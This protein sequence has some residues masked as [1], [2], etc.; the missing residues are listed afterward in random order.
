MNILDKPA[1]FDGCNIFLPLYHRGHLSLFPGA[2]VWLCLIPGNNTSNQ[3]TEL[4][5]SPIQHDAWSDLWRI[6]LTLKE[7]VGLVHDVFRILSAN[8][9][10]IVTAESATKDGMKLHSIEI[11][12]NAREYTNQ[13]DQTSEER[14]RGQGDELEGLRLELLA[15]LIDDIALLPNGDPRLR[16]RRVRG[17]L[18]ARRSY[19]E[20]VA[21]YVNAEAARPI[22]KTSKVIKL[23]KDNKRKVVINLPK[24]LQENLRLALGPAGANGTQNSYLTIS[25]TSERF[26]H[27]YFIK[28]SDAI[29]SPTIEHLDEIGALAKIT[30]T[31]QTAGFN[32]LTTL[33]RLYEWETKARTEFV[34]QPPE[35]FSGSAD[36]KKISRHL[37]QALSSPELVLT[38]GLR[39]GYPTNYVTPFKTKKLRV[40]GKVGHL[41]RQL[42]GRAPDFN[43]EQPPLSKIIGSKKRELNRRRDRRGASVDDL[44]RYHL[45]EQI[46]A[47]FQALAD[48]QQEQR[49]R[50]TLFI[51][52]SFKEAELINHVIKVA[53]RL[54]FDVKVAKKLGKADTTREGILDIMEDCTHFLGIWTE[55]GGTKVE[56]GYYP[57]PWLHWEWGVADALG[58]TWR[59][60]ISSKI[61]EQAWSRIAGSTPHNIFTTATFEQE[62]KDALRLL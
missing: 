17:L 51:S 43:K 53:K 31:I 58:L 40:A 5:I 26:I 38:Y 14:S 13:F 37:E 24:D 18:N 30:A 6:S 39:V 44:M 34:L 41:G 62:L 11:V 42:A 20:A 61:N 12:A 21:N 32:I 2:K 8:S 47:E 46:E 22:V 33:S 27:V 35:R 56:N 3:P 4:I 25:N 52:Y 10:N 57:S 16:I 19:N 55:E 1:L 45:L 29:I 54:R 36:Q 28:E 15:R 23:E 7:R 49:N 48:I 60:L 59:L 50:G 9:F